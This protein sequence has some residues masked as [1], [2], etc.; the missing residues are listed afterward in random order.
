MGE[1]PSTYGDSW[2]Y[3]SIVGALPGVSLSP[4]RS[5]VVQ[6][7]LFE[8]GLFVVAALYDRWNA[9][10][11]GTAAITVATVG[12][13]AMSRIANRIRTADV[14][15][16][17]HRLLFGPNVEVVLAVLAFVAFVTYLFTFDTGGES[18]LA[19]VL[20]ESP[21]MLGVYLLLL[22]CWDLCYRIGTGWWA[23]VTALWR[24]WTY[25]FPPEQ[26]RALSRA[27]GE[28]LAFG[29]LQLGLLPFVTAQPVLVAALLG[30]VVAMV[31]VTGLSLLLLR[32]NRRVTAVSSS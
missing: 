13:L 27:D 22:V 28:T 25:E 19:Q 9:I 21:P 7:V 32:K 30:H 20:G 1:P 31:V 26:A 8:G 29:L 3:E 4:F 16:T 18:L 15:R 12:S 24:S 2:V 6:F 23:S 17:Y 10:P 5:A 14:P 11:A